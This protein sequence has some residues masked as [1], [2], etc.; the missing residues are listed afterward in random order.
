M[1]AVNHWD[2]AID[3]H[4]TNHPDAKHY[5]STVDSLDPR[6][7]VPGGKLDLMI[8]APECC[9]HSI[10]RGGRPINDQSRASAWHILRWAELLHVNTILIENVREFR[11]WGPLTTRGRPIK[12]RKGETYLA[13]LQAL[14]SLGYKVEDR[15]LNAAD[16]GDATTRERLFIIARRG[17]K[18]IKWP[19]PSHAKVPKDNQ[20]LDFGLEPWR[21][22]RDIIDW[23][24]E[25]QSIFTRK[26]PLKPATI[27][28]IVAGLQKFGGVN[29][30]PF[31]VMLR[32]TGTTRSVD[33]PLPTITAQGKHIGLC[34][35][36][37]LQQQ[38]GGAPRS[39]DEPIPTIATKGA[40]SLCE[41]FLVPFFGE[42]D[43][44]GPRTHSVDEPLKTVTGQGAGGLVQPYLVQVNHGGHNHRSRSI[45]RP[46]PALTTKNGLALVDPYLVKYYGSA[47]KVAKSVDEPLDTIPTKD[48]FALV[49]PSVDAEYRLDIRF[50]M[51]QPHELAA[52]QSFGDD[53]H[54]AGN[55]AEQVKQIGNAVPVK[56]SKALCRELIAG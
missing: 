7:V 39:V 20:L 15:I 43:G 35:P 8:A 16:Y 42:R 48:R 45:D 28:R 30:E 47:K 12:S 53:Y 24:I 6:K 40:I 11:N 23:S 19:E 49:E 17:R 51:L 18:N 50:R 33:R 9:H 25:G 46:L 41:P 52:A 56:M 44:Q 2:I 38:S 37:V 27:A 22:A 31:L 3:T 34:E 1:V 13:F 54:F 14:R 10:A 5:C 36:F 32:G 55:K 29:A 26:R 4:S 21:P